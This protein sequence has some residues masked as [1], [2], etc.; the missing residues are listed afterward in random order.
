MTELT[1]AEQAAILAGPKRWTRITNR[2]KNLSWL[3]SAK[4]RRLQ[5][6]LDHMFDGIIYQQGGREIM[7]Q[8]FNDLEPL[9]PEE[10]LCDL[11]I[12]ESVGELLSVDPVPLPPEEEEK[13]I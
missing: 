6:E 12:H 5:Y 1:V 8:D 7:N 9:F 10:D 13:L 4:E 3:W 11:K 2:W